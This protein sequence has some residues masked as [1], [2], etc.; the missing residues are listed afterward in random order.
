MS[1]WAIVV[2]L[3]IHGAVIGGGFLYT[4][5][6][7]KEKKIVLEETLPCTIP[8][9]VTAV[10]E[11]SCAPISR[12]KIEVPVSSD[13]PEKQVVEHLLPEIKPDSVPI[14]PTKEEP[15]VEPLPEPEPKVEPL[16][17]TKSEPK[18]PVV[19]Q[20]VEQPKSEPL[21]VAVPEPEPMP[22]PAAKK[23]KPK[24]IK[25][26]K[27]LMKDVVKN[28]VKDKKS[29]TKK[30]K[31]DKKKTA[32]ADPIL[33]ILKKHEKEVKKKK[34]KPADFISVL[35]DV[36]KDHA[37]GSTGETPITDVNSDSDY[38][39]ASIGPQMSMSTLDRV[40]RLLEK[41]WRV[42]L[43]A[44]EG[45][46]LVVTVIIDMNRDGTVQTATID[47]T[48]GTP[49]HPAYCVAC[50]SALRAVDQF[51]TQPLPLLNDPYDNWKTIEFPF[52]R[53]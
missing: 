53:K 13:D 8:L 11:V 15:K 39:A 7:S 32:P 45:G 25:K 27:P 16:P 30:K 46:A 36:D 33:D 17:E 47:H 1:F 31:K 5:L 52:I 3:M 21:P 34:N 41:A 4:Y 19:E 35:K 10:S 48:Q 49:N 43:R 40:R 2:S 38:G 18:E 9:E 28:A 26:P 24:I 44:N 23:V 37:K 29:D 6:F 51:R 20:V 50:D 42:P 22:Q 12:P 14:E